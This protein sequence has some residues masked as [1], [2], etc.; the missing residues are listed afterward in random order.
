MALGSREP[1]GGLQG[2][3]QQHQ[4]W[5]AY[6]RNGCGELPLISST[7]GASQ[8][9]CIER[10]AQALNTPVCHLGRR[11]KSHLGKTNKQTPQ[12][13]KVWAPRSHSSRMTDPVRPKHD[14]LWSGSWPSRA[15]H[16][17]SSLRS[18]DPRTVWSASHPLDAT[19]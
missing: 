8:A 17:L 3:H 11:K 6:E 4:W 18:L 16:L 10:Q 12:Q 14:N 5:A 19:P 2:P 15:R 7:V 9:V 13:F 1:S